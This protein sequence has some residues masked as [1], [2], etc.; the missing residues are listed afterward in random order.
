[1]W[2]FNCNIFEYSS[3]SSI[4]NAS[5]S[6]RISASPKLT[7]D[8]VS[9][10]ELFNPVERRRWRWLCQSDWYVIDWLMLYWTGQWLLSLK[11]I[12]AFVWR[13]ALSSEFSSVSNLRNLV[14]AVFVL[15]MPALL[16]YK[17]LRNRLKYAFTGPISV[18]FYAFEHWKLFICHFFDFAEFYQIGG[19]GNE[20]WQDYTRESL[21]GL[22]TPIQA[23]KHDNSLTHS[24]PV[25]PVDRGGTAKHHA[26]LHRL[27]G[28]SAALV[29]AT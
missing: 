23:R 29:H 15:K 21:R 26:I 28:L 17:I 12:K 22:V 18:F 7:A 4:V 24:L 11:H 20:A 16:K 3:E 13:L 6:L 1:M 2:I 5:D 27:S 25:V 14:E 10:R 9:R 8:H 19:N